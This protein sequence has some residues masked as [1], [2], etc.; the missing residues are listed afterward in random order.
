MLD[1]ADLGAVVLGGTRP[2]TL[3]RAGRLHADPAVLG[4]ADAM[5]V[6]DRDPWASTWF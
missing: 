5:F 2:S 6:A 3:A 4:R 1:A